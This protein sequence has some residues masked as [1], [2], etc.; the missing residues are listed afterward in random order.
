MGR[1]GAGGGMKRMAGNSNGRWSSC[2]VVLPIHENKDW[3]MSDFLLIFIS[4]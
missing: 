2:L 3:W 4:L 1:R